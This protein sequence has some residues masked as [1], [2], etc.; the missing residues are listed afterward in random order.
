[1]CTKTS[2]KKNVKP[3]TRNVTDERITERTTGE[4]SNARTFSNSRARFTKIIRWVLK[5][6][7]FSTTKWFLIFIVCLMSSFL[8]I[9]AS[10]VH[11]LRVRIRTHYHQSRSRAGAVMSRGRFLTSKCRLAS[12]A[13]LAHRVWCS[14]RKVAPLRGRELCWRLAFSVI[15][16][17]FSER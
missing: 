7:I 6:I 17:G 15:L 12:A 9:F 13:T 11:F 16:V 2:V 1:M 14:W 3:R 8:T 5:R 4:E 10:W